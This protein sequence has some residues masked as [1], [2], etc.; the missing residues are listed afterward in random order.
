MFQEIGRRDP[1]LEQVRG[2]E[3]QHQNQSWTSNLGSWHHQVKEALVTELKVRPLYI[4]TIWAF[5][6]SIY[7]VLD[8]FTVLFGL[9]Y[10]FNIY[11]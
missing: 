9:L 5:T 3:I 10:Y 7:E 4:E 1:D 11:R 6:S 2:V 8:W